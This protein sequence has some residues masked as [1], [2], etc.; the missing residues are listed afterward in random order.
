M[1][2]HNYK[3][4]KAEEVQVNLRGSSQPQE[5]K[6]ALE[7]QV[8]LTS[9]SQTQKFKSTSEVH[10]SQRSSSPMKTSLYG[11]ELPGAEVLTWC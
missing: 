9:S 7:V 2:F 1:V 5:F 8:S 6:S 11:I 3:I 4:T 10:V